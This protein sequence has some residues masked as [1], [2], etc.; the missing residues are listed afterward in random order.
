MTYIIN[1]KITLPVLDKHTLSFFK[2][3]Y[4]LYLQ[5]SKNTRRS[6]ENENEMLIAI[7]NIW[8]STSYEIL[9]FHRKNFNEDRIIFRKSIIIFGPHGGAFA[10]LIF[11]Q[12]GTHVDL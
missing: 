4:I 6:V 8:K 1:K 9:I 5:R 7:N 3:R 11:A 10:N 12:P 2:L